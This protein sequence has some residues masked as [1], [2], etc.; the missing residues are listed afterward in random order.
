MLENEGIKN[1]HFS[2]LLFILRC[3]AIRN[4]LT[5]KTIYNK[6]FINYGYKG[7]VFS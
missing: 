7:T 2:L 5:F 3:T 1:P 4:F 6:L